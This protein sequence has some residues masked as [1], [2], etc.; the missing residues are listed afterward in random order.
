MVFFNRFSDCVNSLVAPNHTSTRMLT[1]MAFAPLVIIIHELGHALAVRLLHKNNP[2]E[3]KLSM[4]GYGGGKVLFNKDCELSELGK[5]VGKNNSEA[6]IYAAGPVVQMVA[7]FA[8]MQFFPKNGISL[9]G[10]TA[11]GEYAARTLFDKAY[12]K[13]KEDEKTAI[14]DFSKIKILKG[15][16]FAETLIIT[17][18]GAGV[19]AVNK[20]VKNLY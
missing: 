10:L 6:I 12:Y 3:I 13:G 9:F 20:S 16:L 2:I 5:L 18:I 15:G 7:S 11:N 17:S 1:G 4:G 8:L 19:W 14:G